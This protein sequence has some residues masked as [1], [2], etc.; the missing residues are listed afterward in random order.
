MSSPEIRV[1]LVSTTL[2]PP[3][4]DTAEVWMGCPSI[5]WR[6]AA[7]KRVSSL[8]WILVREEVSTQDVYSPRARENNGWSATPGTKVQWRIGVEEPE[9]AE[10]VEQYGTT[11]PTRKQAL[12]AFD[13]V[14]F[15]R[16]QSWSLDI[17]EDNYS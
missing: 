17:R 14:V 5:Q 4:I 12:A 10:E 9:F 6:E 13:S 7:A 15:E 11:Y 16:Y 1:A 8:H 3:P 2:T